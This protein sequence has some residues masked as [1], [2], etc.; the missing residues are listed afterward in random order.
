[1]CQNSFSLSSQTF[2]QNGN[3][4]E[5]IYENI[6]SLNNLNEKIKSF[7][8]VVFKDSCIYNIPLV[9]DKTI[10]DILFVTNVEFNQNYKVMLSNIIDRAKNLNNEECQDI[11]LN[12][13]AGKNIIYTE[14]ELMEY[15]YSLIEQI[16]IEN[17][18]YEC[19]TKY[20]V[21]LKIHTRIKDS[22]KT[23]QGDG[24]RAFAKDIVKSLKH[25]EKDFKEILEESSELTEALQKFSTI[26]G[27]ETS[28]EG[29]VRRKS[30][31]TF[32]FNE[33]NGTEID[34]CCEPHI[35]ISKSSIPGDGVFYTN[36]LYFYQGREDVE[37][38]KILIGH[39]GE[40]L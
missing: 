38:G 26:L 6:K 20:F 23:L 2:Q 4:K 10:C 27:I 31:F 16:F 14:Y 28:L 19:A 8:D 25:L 5:T 9:D 22:L 35:K 13:I 33:N 37:N 18:F 21:K 30:F 39:I 29:N 34:I 11:G 36:R 15:Y 17:D 7:N 1:M 3:T 12:K 24:L 32:T 40:H